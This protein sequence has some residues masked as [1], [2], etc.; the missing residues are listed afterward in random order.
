[1]GKREV[2]QALELLEVPIDTL[3]TTTPPPPQPLAIYHTGLMLN[4]FWARLLQSFF[5]QANELNTKYSFIRVTVRD[6]LPVFVYP[7]I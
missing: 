5:L 6:G 7:V 1:M 3:G 4:W 2:Q